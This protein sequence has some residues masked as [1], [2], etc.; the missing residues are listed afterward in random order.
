MKFKGNRKSL[1]I[2]K[3]EPILSNSI[4]YFYFRTDQLLELFEDAPD[5]TANWGEAIDTQEKLYKSS[6]DESSSESDSDE[7]KNGEDSPRKKVNFTNY[8]D[9]K[10]DR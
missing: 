6:S 5:D 2:T 1:I 10:A 8:Q 3:C 7:H 9:E 4:K